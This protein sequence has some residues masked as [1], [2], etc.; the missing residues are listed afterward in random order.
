MAWY[1]TGTIA[2]SGTTVTG[3]GT[4]W[5]DN[6][7]AIGPG[8]A[9]LIPG[10]GTV[11]MYEIKSVDSATKITLMTSPGTLAAGQAYS[12]MSFYTDSVPD[13]ARRLAAQLSYYQTQMDGWQQIMTGSGSI[14]L[15]A[16]DGTNVTIS[17]FAKLT[18]DMAALSGAI[19]QRGTTGS[20]VTD[21][22]MMS[23]QA[24]YSGIW[25]FSSAAQYN[26][27]N[28]PEP[29]SGVL[30]VFIGG[31][32]SCAQR[33]TTRYGNIYTRTLSA[34]WSATTP[35]WSEWIPAGAGTVYTQVISGSANDIN[36]PGRYFL[37]DAVTDLPITSSGVLEV[38]RR[39]IGSKT[40][41]IQEYHTDTASA[42]TGNRKFIRLCSGGTFVAWVELLST[43]TT[44]PIANGGTGG[45]TQATARTGLGLG[46]AATLNVN[47]S[48]AD[49][50][51]GAPI[52]AGSQVNSNNT[53]AALTF[54][55]NI[56]PPMANVTNGTNAPGFRVS[57]GANS[58]AS[59]AM[60]FIRDGAYA[61]LFGID[62]DN[63]LKIGGWSNGANSYVIWSQK[64]TTVD[65]NGFIK[66][67]SPIVRVT[68]NV[69]KMPA[70]F[71]EGNFTQTDYA[72][73]NDEAEGV[74]VECVDVGLYHIAGTAGLYPDGWTLEIP[75]DENGN[76]LCYA[77]LSYQEGVV[78]LNV[79]KRKFDV[80]S[81]MIVA[82]DPVDVPDGRWID[83]R[84]A[85]PGDSVFN[86][87]AAQATVELREYLAA[88]QKA[89]EEAEQ[90]AI[91]AAEAE[92]LAEAQAAAEQT[93]QQS[94]EL[95]SE[96][97][98]TDT[99]LNDQPEI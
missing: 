87:K 54:A 17:S 20:E 61:T 93:S 75:Q 73:V 53:I 70:G 12:I 10:S 67:A 51:A 80:D 24:G 59:A 21:V 58:S 79:A 4:N 16:P 50:V 46:N 15:T 72:A 14:T 62:A 47:P 78:I 43:K 81:A 38:K 83:V 35:S 37:S 85:M 41:F 96:P 94:D 99:D 65:G 77:S 89:Q 90:A 69:S 63:Q 95:P 86:Q 7:F 98:S 52:V 82:G 60:V 2:V 23:Q 55:S 92:A 91:A 22:N 36:L 56:T 74:T 66:K 31:A 19:L 42:A 1:N 45:T 64:N 44:V 34:N 5:L 76:R 71:T 9:L 48:G 27:L 18:S 28:L 84:V 29:V 57:N 26:L 33:Y 8:Q 3:T 40:S 97:A 25:N 88:Q 6:K 49:P 32:F 13:F 30:E 68:S 39:S 11:K